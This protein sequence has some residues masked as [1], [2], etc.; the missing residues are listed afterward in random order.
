ME[1]NQI[2]HRGEL[3]IGIDVN[4]EL[5]S[6]YVGN[7]SLYIGRLYTSEWMIPELIYNA[8]KSYGIG[9]LSEW[10]SPPVGG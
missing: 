6:I 4:V 9:F 3:S 8:S 7:I 5:L 2:Q 10:L 1:G